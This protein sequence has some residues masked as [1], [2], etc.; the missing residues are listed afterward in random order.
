MISIF[1]FDQYLLFSMARD[2][3]KM[4]EEKRR[5]SLGL[6]KKRV[7]IMEQVL[8]KFISKQFLTTNSL[9]H[10]LFS[11][12]ELNLDL[13]ESEFLRMMFGT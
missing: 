10:N 11:S 4:Q 5:S 1:S 9:F 8:D 7:K 13:A 6:N 3:N 2:Y 12:E